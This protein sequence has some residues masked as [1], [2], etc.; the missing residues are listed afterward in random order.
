M[1]VPIGHVFTLA[2]AA[3]AAVGLFIEWYHFTQSMPDRGW[4][5]Q[6]AR[7]LGL[8]FLNLFFT[9]LLASIV[10]LVVW[11]RLAS[12]LPDLQGWHLQIP[13]SEFCAD[14]AKANYEYSL[15]SGEFIVATV[16]YSP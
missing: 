10:V 11:V 5:L 6:V 1:H 15:G 9:A 12:T 13:D 7:L 16:L 14:Y 8:V 4:N 2:C 3:W